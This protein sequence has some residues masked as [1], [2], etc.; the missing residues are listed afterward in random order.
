MFKNI[1][2][3]IQPY[4]ISDKNFVYVRGVYLPA[5]KKKAVIVL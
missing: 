5:A 2:L 4:G 3:I 1:R